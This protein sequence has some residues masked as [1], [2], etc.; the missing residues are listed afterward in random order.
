M[1]GYFII[2]LDF[3]LFW[4]VSE[5]RTIE[6]Y[7]QNLL[8][9][10]E[11]VERLLMIFSENNIQASWACVGFLFF[12]NKNELNS[13]MVDY[14]KLPKYK[15]A[16]LNNFDLIS[17][18]DPI[19]EKFYFAKNLINKIKDTKGQEIC[20]HTFSH[21]YTLEDGI[22]DDDF[23]SD[24]KAAISSAKKN[25]IVIE[26][27]IFPRN[28]YDKKIISIC[29]DFD[30]KS[31]RGNQRHIIYSPSVKQN[32][33]KRLIRLLDSYFSITGNH[34]FA[35]QKTNKPLNIP[36]SRF[37]RPYNKRLSFFEK[38]KVNR[39]LN[40]M[41]YAARNNLNYHLWWHPHNF[42]D[43]IE[44]NFINLYTIVEHQNYLNKKYN[45]TS[46][47]MKNLQKLIS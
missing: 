46:V 42:G 12:E 34:S 18:I 29:N 2:S 15:K 17:Q 16:N 20:T 21:C 4:G 22:T 7:K 14:K 45:F 1:N 19:D 37:L 6:S 38:F 25:N 31:Y 8:K 3:E 13:F 27:I 32:Y 5:K 11:V 26:S 28:Q 30:I 44:E 47:N 9:T 40:E 35:L 36:A 10:P 24:I 43:N 41:T 23:Y 33:L 39:V